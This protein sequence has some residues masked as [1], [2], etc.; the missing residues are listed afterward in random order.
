MPTVE[1]TPEQILILRR[2][3]DAGAPIHE[4]F[5][6]RKY[7]V[8]E[9]VVDVLRHF[10]CNTYTAT[11]QLEFFFTRE[12]AFTLEICF[13]IGARNM[14]ANDDWRAVSAIIRAAV[15]QVGFV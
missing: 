2:G 4:D 12:E 9:V 13:N 14:V 15:S 7:P 3:F 1:F 8:K 6:T 11:P 5:A 10:L